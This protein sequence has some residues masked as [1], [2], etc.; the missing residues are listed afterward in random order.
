MDASSCVF[1]ELFTKGRKKAPL[2]NYALLT[3]CEALWF[4]FKMSV[5]HESSLSDSNT[6]KKK[7]K[8]KKDSDLK[9][10]K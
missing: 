3:Q 5:E 4:C 10:W 1:T 9:N 7:D 2:Q 6:N 8:K